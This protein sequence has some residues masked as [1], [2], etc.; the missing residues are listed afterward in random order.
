MTKN[1]Y[2]APFIPRDTWRCDVARS[3]DLLRYTT[4][5][6]LRRP[7]LPVFNSAIAPPI[8]TVCH[9]SRLGYPGRPRG[10]HDHAQIRAR[11]FS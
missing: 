11:T 8:A 1:A 7:A 4:K 9:T 3:K 10:A 5:R 6:G 2:V